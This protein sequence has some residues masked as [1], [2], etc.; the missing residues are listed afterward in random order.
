MGFDKPDLGFVVHLGAPS[1]P[2]AYY[3]QV[4]RAGR[5]TERADV[6][7]LPG[8]EDRDIWRYFA[9]ASMPRQ[10]QAAAVLDALGGGRPADVDCGAGD[11]HRRPA[12]PARAAAQGARRR[13]RRAS[14]SP[15]A[16]SRPESRGSTTPSGT[17]GSPQAREREAAAMLDVRADDGLP[18][19]LPRRGAR[20]PGGCRLRAVRPLRRRRRRRALVPRRRAG[21]R[22]DG[23]SGTAAARRGRARP[24]GPMAVRDGPARR[25]RQWARSPTGSGSARAGSWP[26]SPTSA[27]AP[28]CARSSTRTRPTPPPTTRSSPRASR[29][30]RAGAGRAVPPRSRPSRPGVGR[31]SSR[32]SPATSPR[33]PARLARAAR[34]RPARGRPASPAATA[35]SGSPGS[36]TPSTSRRPWRRRLAGLDGAPVL[37]VDDLVDSR[38]TLTVAGRALRLAGAGEVL[39][40]A[41][42]SVG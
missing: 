19:A 31:S 22:A 14:G 8:P 10:D 20:R 36:G 33:R 42:A 11:R 34:R 40:F 4:G 24:A 29:C 17:P 23:G 18:D 21:R 35:R 9:T 39:P 6:L 28:G 37:L 41:L 5:A 12:D 26:G 1:S 13:R 15:A 30:S 3:Q 2:V 38:W 7:L 27:G 25:A 32:P 16:G